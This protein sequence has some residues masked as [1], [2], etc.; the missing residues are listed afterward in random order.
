MHGDI[1]KTARKKK[2][3]SMQDLVD[4]LYNRHK[5]ATTRQNINR[6]EKDDLITPNY[7]H[8]HMIYD[9]LELERG[10]LPEIKGNILTSGDDALLSELERVKLELKEVSEK[11]RK[12]RAT[13]LAMKALLSRSR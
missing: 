5:W 9:V 3:W 1:I 12:E 8:I 7:E 2:G 6:Y 11:L 4:E 13:V 10:T